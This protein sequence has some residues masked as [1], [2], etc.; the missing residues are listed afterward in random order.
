MCLRK[1]FKTCC[2]LEKIS[3]SPDAR[4]LVSARV[5]YS[6]N[7]GRCTTHC[8]RYTGKNRYYLA[9]LTVSYILAKIDTI[10]LTLSVSELCDLENPDKATDLISILSCLKVVFLLILLQSSHWVSSYNIDNLW[11]Y[12]FCLDFAVSVILWPYE[13]RSKLQNQFHFLPKINSYKFI[14]NLLTG[15]GDHYF[16]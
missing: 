7:F 12:Y 14:H 5:I 13:M 11:Q 8:F 4:N 3:R 9:L 2:D 6:L 16:A 10:W 15:L 1:Q